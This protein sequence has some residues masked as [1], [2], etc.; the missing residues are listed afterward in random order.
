MREES[1]GGCG[2]G[3]RWDGVKERFGGEKVCG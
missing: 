2:G 3:L 1:L